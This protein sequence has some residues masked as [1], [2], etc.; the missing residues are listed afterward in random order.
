MGDIRN[1]NPAIVREEDDGGGAPRNFVLTVKE[2]R[3]G[4]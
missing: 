1:V 2:R 4:G 3:F